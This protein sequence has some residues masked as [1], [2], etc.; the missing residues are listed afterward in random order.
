MATCAFCNILLELRMFR[1]QS[2][3][4]RAKFCSR[5]CYEASRCQ[6][7]VEVTC[8]QC[9]NRFHQIISRQKRKEFC[10]V[11]CQ[12]DA[13]L[14]D[15]HKYTTSQGYIAVKN[16]G[17]PLAYSDGYVLEHRLVMCQKL[18][19]ILTQ[20]EHIHHIDGNKTNNRPENLELVDNSTH[21]IIHASHERLN[22]PEAIDKR[23]TTRAKCV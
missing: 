23:V 4:K 9:D 8:P 6:K 14:R 20:H 13:R 15:G 12:Y 11:K 3:Y 19:R 10:S 16:H 2:Q 7:I 5:S 1:D 21:Q 17:H 18:G 22:T